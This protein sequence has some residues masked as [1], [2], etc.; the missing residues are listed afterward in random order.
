MFYLDREVKGMDIDVTTRGGVVTLEGTVD[1]EAVKK[2]AVADARSTE[3]VK[4]VVDR[5]TVRK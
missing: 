3:G 4:Q 1:S 5:L 2:K